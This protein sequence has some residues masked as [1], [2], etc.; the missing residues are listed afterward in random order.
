[1]ASGTIQGN[2]LTSNF[3]GSASFGGRPD[4]AKSVA[5]R[6]TLVINN[7]NVGAAFQGGNGSRNPPKVQNGD[8][9][10][11]LSVEVFGSEFRGNGSV[12]PNFAS[13]GLS[14]LVNDDSRSDP[15]QA[16][17]IE[18]QV[19]D[20]SFIENSNWGVAVAQ[21]IAPNVPEIGYQ[22]EGTFERNRYCGNGFNPAIFDFRQ[23]TTTLSPLLPQTHFRYARGSTYIIHAEN[24][25]LASIG[26]DL[27]HPAI[28]PDPPGGPLGN[29]LIFDGMTVPTAPL[30][31]KRPTAVIGCTSLRANGP[32]ANPA[33]LFLGLASAALTPKYRDSASVKFAGG[34]VFRE[35]GTWATTPSAE[36]LSSAGDL[37]TWIGL[38]NSDDQG[39]RF[40]L[41]AELYKNGM[42]FTQGLTRCIQGV[43][44][45]PDSAE[46]VTVAFDPF[47]TTAFSGSDVLALRVLTRI[48]T[49]TD[50]SLCGGHS[51]AVGL[52]LYFDSTNRPSSFEQNP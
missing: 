30:M 41:Q 24:D 38:K 51:N 21:R 32:D 19:H 1:M 7:S 44:R 16:A 35:I 45:N 31:L 12:G 22:F 39:T 42:L 40:D 3:S 20:N 33:D 37:Y 25:P 48:G 47:P 27:D 8:G 52:R 50:G 4:L 17:S 46:Q 36:S 15:T 29:T 43:T 34:N 14:F 9:P 49:N 13:L 26:F 11:S 6:D 5:F 28:D 23:V 2:R 10:G 18:A